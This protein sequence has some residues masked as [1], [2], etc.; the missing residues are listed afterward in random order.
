M[1][2]KLL[3]LGLGLTMS[4]LGVA[5]VPAAAAF[6]DT[7]VQ[8]ATCYTGCTTPATGTSTPVTVAPQP[9]QVAPVQEPAA[10]G[11]P[12]TGADIEEMAAVGAGAL[13]LGGVMV[14]RSRR[15]RQATA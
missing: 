9:L 7:S 2:S 3:G 8:P 15:Q 12:F 1:K 6:A 11:L 14:R 13:V 5:A 10:S 4:A